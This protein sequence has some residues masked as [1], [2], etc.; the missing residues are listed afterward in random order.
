MDTE[1][2]QEAMQYLTFVLAGE[3]YGISIL[4]VQEIRSY[5][6]TTRIPGTPAYL[7][8]VINLRGSVVPIV[9]LRLKFELRDAEGEVN[10]V[11]ILVKISTQNKES[12][13]GIVVDAVSDVY[14]I[15]AQDVTTAPD[16]ASNSVKAFVT[17][18]ATV[19]S[20]M[21]ILLDI[22]ALINAGILDENSLIHAT[23]YEDKGAEI[24]SK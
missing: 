12:T 4:K 5:E 6:T 24:V 1:D 18:L 7:L 20:K 23:E 21:I 2:Q 16:I 8:G 22:D 11:I 9:D 17:G 13:I 3:E 10:P 15:G 19:D 14:A